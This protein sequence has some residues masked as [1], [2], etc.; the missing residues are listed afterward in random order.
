MSTKAQTSGLESRIF[1]IGSGLTLGGSILVGLTFSFKT[2]ISF[3]AGG[4]L[5]GLNLLWLRQTIGSALSRNA[6]ASKARLLAGFF[7]RLLLIP[8]SL[9]VMLRFLFLS[10][11]A[12]VA[13]FALFNCSIFFEGVLEVFG[14]R[15]KPRRKQ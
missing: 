11:P 4:A 5:G 1:W 14:S 3:L 8:V 6:E 12:A 13:G 9:Y 15:S 10:V 2:G 7:F